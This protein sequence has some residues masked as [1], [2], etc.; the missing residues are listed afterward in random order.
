MANKLI[1]YFA[2]NGTASY[3]DDYTFFSD[4][5]NIEFNSTNYWLCT[6]TGAMD[7]ETGPDDYADY[8]ATVA[9]I[10]IIVTGMVNYVKHSP[11]FTKATIFENSTITVNGTLAIP[12]QAFAVPIRRN[13]GRL[14][15]FLANVVAGEF[16]VPINFPT[17]GSF[18]YS[19]DEANIDLPPGTF[20]VNTMTFDVLRVIPA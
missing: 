6:Y 9:P 11:D 19:D 7:L 18:T 14:F 16:S 13:D 20:T 2:I 10:P 1:P 17:T 3:P 12:D 5:E 8:A 15:Y 4:M